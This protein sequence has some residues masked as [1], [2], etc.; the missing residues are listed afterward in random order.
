MVHPAIAAL[1]TDLGLAAFA[2]RQIGPAATQLA[3]RSCG[4]RRSQ[5]KEIVRRAMRN[6]LER[7]PLCTEVTRASGE[8]VKTTGDLRH[9]QRTGRAIPMMM[10]L[11]TGDRAW[12][13]I[14][15]ILV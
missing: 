11:T 5:V 14:A 15:A 2:D 12:T 8:A 13:W 10:L 9:H 6:D 1:E 3:V 7:L 4:S